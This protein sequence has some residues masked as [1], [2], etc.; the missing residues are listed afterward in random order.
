PQHAGATDI[1]GGVEHVRLLVVVDSDP[2]AVHARG[3]MAGLDERDLDAAGAVLRGLQMD[4]R[5]GG[6]DLRARDPVGFGR[7]R[8]H[9]GDSGEGGG[10]EAEDEARTFVH[11]AA[12]P[13]REDPPD[14]G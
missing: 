8:G 10:G 11:D 14:Y 7:R 9:A 5:F 4:L 3:R 1:A 12:L 13:G 6:A 2:R